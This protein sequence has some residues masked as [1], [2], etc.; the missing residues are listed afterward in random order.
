MCKENPLFISV[1]SVLIVLSE[2]FD[3][4][5]DV[6]EFLEIL[7]HYAEFIVSTL[8]WVNWIID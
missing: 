4:G 7:I 6:E 2:T 1:I 8:N 5:R 3:A